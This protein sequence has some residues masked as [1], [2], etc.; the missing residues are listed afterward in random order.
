M[1]LCFGRS[2]SILHA[3]GA[4]A[5]HTATEGCSLTNFIAFIG[6]PEEDLPSSSYGAYGTP[7]RCEAHNLWIR[8]LGWWKRELHG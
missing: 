7:R 5:R 2:C 6:L 1:Y 8:E 3:T 4:S